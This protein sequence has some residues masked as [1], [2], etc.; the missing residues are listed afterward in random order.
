MCF[1]ICDFCLLSL[2]NETHHYTLKDPDS[3]MAVH[4]GAGL[5]PEELDSPYA[6]LLVSQPTP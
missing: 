3:S 6:C 4:V 2:T 1:V 5:A